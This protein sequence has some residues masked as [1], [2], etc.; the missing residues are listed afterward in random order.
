MNAGQVFLNPVAPPTLRLATYGALAAA[1]RETVVTSE[2]K[3]STGRS[4]IAITA[5]DTGSTPASD[6]TISYLL[7][8]TTGLPPEDV[9]ASSTGAVIDRI[10]INSITTTNTLPTNPYL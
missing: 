1:A 3:D 9:A 5:K 4:R 2:V 8:P 7:D 10:T 6:G